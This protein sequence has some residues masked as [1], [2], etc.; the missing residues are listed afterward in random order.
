METIILASGSP[1]RRELLTKVKLPIKVIPPDVAEDYTPDLPVP[2]M[3]V[4]IARSKVEAVLALFK[5]ESPRWVLGLDTVVEIDGKVLGKPP[6]PDEAEAMLR[7]LS[8][9][10]HR[11]YSGIALL[12]ERGKPIEEEVVCT[13]VKFRAME[14]AEIRFYIESGEWAGAAGAYRIQ[15]RGAFLVD[16]I[17]GSYSNVVGLPLE[18]FYGILVRNEYHF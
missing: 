13:E 12:V 18:A 3:V 11:V 10:I 17:K 15:E 2:E 1:R 14:A 4:R 16:W 6:G 5:T 8:G 9:R 7:M